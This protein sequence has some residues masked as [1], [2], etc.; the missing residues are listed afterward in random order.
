MRLTVPG[1]YAVTKELFQLAIDLAKA[2]ARYDIAVK[3]QN[4]TRKSAVLAQVRAN[5]C[6]RELED[7]EERWKKATNPEIKLAE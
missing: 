4:A 6:F 1:E 7:L 5:A 3:M 2:Q